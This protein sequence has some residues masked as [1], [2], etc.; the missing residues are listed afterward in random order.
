MRFVWIIVGVYCRGAR[1]RGVELLKLVII[2][3]M[4][5]HLSDFLRCVAILYSCTL[6][7]TIIERAEQD[8]RR[9]RTDAPSLC[10]IAEFLVIAASINLSFLQLGNDCVRSSLTGKFHFVA[11]QSTS[12]SARS[13]FIQS[14]MASSKSHNIRT[15]S[16]PSVK[17]TLSWIRHSRSFKV[18]LIGAGRNPDWCDNCRNVQPMLSSPYIIL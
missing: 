2:H 9:P 15:S 8:V 6:N 5:N 13:L 17:R 18:I 11:D 10:G 16:V 1:R 3:F 12:F 14:R 7:C 4:Q